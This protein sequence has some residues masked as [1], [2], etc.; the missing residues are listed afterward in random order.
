MR[1]AILAGIV[2]ALAVLTIPNLIDASYQAGYAIRDD[3]PIESVVRTF[4]WH[5]TEY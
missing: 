2:G 1:K 5:A 3:A 4:I